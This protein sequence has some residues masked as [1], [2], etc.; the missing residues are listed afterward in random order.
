VKKPK[1]VLHPNIVGDVYIKDRFL[2]N[3]YDNLRVMFVTYA[4][5]SFAFH[6]KEQSLNQA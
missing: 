4:L 2:S 6:N 1:R 3:F 5:A